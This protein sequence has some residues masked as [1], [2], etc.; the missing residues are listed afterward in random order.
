MEKKIGKTFDTALLQLMTVSFVL[1][2]SIVNYEN[3]CK[4]F[5]S[6]EFSHNAKMTL[7]HA[8]IYCF[9]Y[10][11]GKKI[12]LNFYEDRLKFLAS[13]HIIY[14][15]CTI[16]TKWFFNIRSAI[17]LSW[18]ANSKTKKKLRQLNIE[19]NSFKMNFSFKWNRKITV[20][21]VLS[22]SFTTYLDRQ[23]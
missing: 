20:L 23:A 8:L 11:K 4:W 9:I 17:N 19:H 1:I 13:S 3:Q 18:F 10:L 22:I 6:Y 21:K 5:I 12:I 16:A 15:V 2:R 14:L 7:W